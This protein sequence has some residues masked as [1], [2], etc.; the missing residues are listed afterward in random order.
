[1][2]VITS[3]KIVTPKIFNVLLK[4]LLIIFFLSKRKNTNNVAIKDIIKLN[5][6]VKNSIGGKTNK[7]HIGK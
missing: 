5:D 4:K 7:I 3:T 2:S 6:N 1:M